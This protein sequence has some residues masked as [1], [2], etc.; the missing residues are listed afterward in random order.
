MEDEDNI[1]LLQG[2]AVKVVDPLYNGSSPW[3]IPKFMSLLLSVS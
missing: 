2:S 1:Y 3:F